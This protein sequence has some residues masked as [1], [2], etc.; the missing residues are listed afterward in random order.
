[1]VGHQKTTWS[2]ADGSEE[3]RRPLLPSDGDLD[4][5]FD[6]DDV[7]CEDSHGRTYLQSKG[8]GSATIDPNVWQAPDDKINLDALQDV[9]VYHGPV[10]KE[11]KIACSEN[12]LCLLETA[13]MEE[14]AAAPPEVSHNK[15]ATAAKRHREM[16][17]LHMAQRIVLCEMTRTGYRRQ[18]SEQHADGLNVLAGHRIHPTEEE[19]MSIVG[20]LHE[21]MGRSFDIRKVLG[22]PTGEA[23]IQLPSTLLKWILLNDDLRSCCT[24]P[25]IEDAVAIY[26]AEPGRKTQANFAAILTALEIEGDVSDVLDV[27]KSI[28]RADDCVLYFKPSAVNKHANMLLSQPD[29]PDDCQ[30]EALAVMHYNT[31]ALLVLG[32]YM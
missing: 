30:E 18:V 2:R 14:R 32:V 3:E 5:D 20:E 31:N 15:Q 9:R 1:M 21:E 7:V 10:T 17:A 22:G 4:S 6:D 13:F 8:A 23:G 12:A 26:F 16:T 19:V 24:F 28:I 11:E 29:R 25:K 27:S